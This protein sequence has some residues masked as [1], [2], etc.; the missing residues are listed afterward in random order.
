LG[1]L[2]E[3]AAAFGIA[4]AGGGE[5]F[6]RHEP[7][8]ASIMGFINIAHAAGAQFFQELIMRNDTPNEFHC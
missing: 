4:R 1:F 2:D 7:V 3:T 5:D 6:D 8:Q